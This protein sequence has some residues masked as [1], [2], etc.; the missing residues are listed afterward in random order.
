MLRGSVPYLPKGTKYVNPVGVESRLEWKN[1]TSSMH[2]TLYC[3]CLASSS[4][5]CAVHV[6]WLALSDKITHY[7]RIP[8]AICTWLC[9]VSALLLAIALKV[10]ALWQ[11]LSD[12]ILY[13]L[14]LCFVS[15]HGWYWRFYGWPSLKKF[16]HFLSNLTAFVFKTKPPDFIKLAQHLKYVLHNGSLYDK[17][18]TFSMF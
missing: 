14:R 17:E 5:H 9:I 18:S 2:M 8:Q 7:G 6:L 3:L 15:C 1:A 12:K 11:A 16:Y 13:C 10:H 4:R